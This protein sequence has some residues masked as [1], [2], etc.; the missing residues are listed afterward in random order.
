MVVTDDQLSTK[1]KYGSISFM[2][3]SLDFYKEVS[4]SA[5]SVLII[6]VECYTTLE[7]SYLWLMMSFSWAILGNNIDRI[8]KPV[9]L[10]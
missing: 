10:F 2:E 8:L 1:Y 9:A 7:K 6:S 3:T 4:Q 5:V